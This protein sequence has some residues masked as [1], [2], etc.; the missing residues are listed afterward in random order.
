MELRFSI[1]KVLAYFDIFS[2]PVTTED[3]L[4][5]LDREAG[6]AE[7]KQEV[8]ALVREGK[9]FR[10]GDYYSLRDNPALA[11]RRVNGEKHADHL[12][13]I[14]D[15]GAHF[16]YQ[17][18]F[19]RGVCISGSLS[20]RCAD[21]EA[22]IDYFIIT[23]ANRLW[24]ART[25]MHFFKKLTYLK[26]HQHRYCMNYY[27]DEEALEIKEKNIFTATELITL[28]P[29]SGNGGLENF[30]Q[31]NNWTTLFLPH[32][33]QRNRKAPGT[34][35]TSFL[36]RTFER[37]FDNKLGE[38]LDNYLHDVTERRW[39]RKEQRGDLNMKGLTMTLQC[40]KHYSRPNP[41]VFQQKVLTRYQQKVRE[42]SSQWTSKVMSGS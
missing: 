42:A 17:F 9:L 35:K 12:L 25:I 39:K 34:P 36:K 31:A 26:G 18:P 33:R 10:I 19:V 16:L 6:E 41:E 4:F 29:A 27:V 38:K 8:T 13:K 5:F 7:V 24:I 15:R 22:D 28:M 23:K 1:L 21:E 14:A 11:D 30:F 3:I 32:Y 20:K 40:N 2:Y 37:F